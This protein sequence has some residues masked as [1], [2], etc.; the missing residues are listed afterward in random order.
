[1]SRIAKISDLPSTIHA[2]ARLSRLFPTSSAWAIR[3][4][5]AEDQGVYQSEAMLPDA[6]HP[7]LLQ[8]LPRVQAKTAQKG[9]EIHGDGRVFLCARRRP[10]VP[11]SS[12][13]WPLPFR[14]PC[15]RRSAW[16]SLCLIG[17]P[18]GGPKTSALFEGHPTSRCTRP[19]D[20]RPLP[21]ELRVMQLCSIPIRDSDN[22]LCRIASM[23]RSRSDWSP[24]PR[25]ALLR[26]R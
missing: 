22:W 14:G 17:L 11:L 19:P 26:F 24:A 20:D 4:I 18:E 8:H 16:S 13:F 5:F 3:M 21:A 12:Y 23:R 1:M 9:A 7:V 2:S 25:E 10:R 6:D 15:S